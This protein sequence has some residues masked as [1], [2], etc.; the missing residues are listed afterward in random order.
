MH[1]PASLLGHNAIVPDVLRQPDWV[2]VGL[3]LAIAGT[4][5]LANAILF[6]DPR[7]ML[8]DA[9]GLERQRLG[10]I[11]TYIFHRVQVTLGFLLMLSG[12]ALQLFG[13]SSQEFDTTREFP[14]LWVGL[15][16]AAVALAQ[17]LGWWISRR[18]F[19]RYVRQML[20]E[21]DVELESDSKL[22]R[23]VGELFDVEMLNE[24]TVQSYAARVRAR[25]RLP[26]PSATAVLH[27]DA[28]DGREPR[29]PR[30][31]RFAAGGARRPNPRELDDD[32][33]GS[34]ELTIEEE[35]V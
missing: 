6:R 27:R 12:F 25:V 4:F 18:L 26:R 24:D 20:I 19:Q 8:R 5:L 30:A 17:L 33:L 11:R 28:R 13:R 31:A 34:D 2:V 23:E 14:I 3:V 15:T 32:E 9:F 1:A 16:V 22:T 29:V 7:E 10:S 21:G 35:A